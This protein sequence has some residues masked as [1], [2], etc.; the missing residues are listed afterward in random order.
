[1]REP[2][3]CALKSPQKLPLQDEPEKVKGEETSL[4]TQ[5]TSTK[6]TRITRW[7]TCLREPLEKMITSPQMITSLAT[8]EDDNIASTIIFATMS[9][10][11]T[12]KLATTIICHGNGQTDASFKAS[13]SSM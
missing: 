6:G 3:P 4:L 8:R 1:M 12:Q 7:V 11:T 10:P 9:I 5:R 13:Q 2:N